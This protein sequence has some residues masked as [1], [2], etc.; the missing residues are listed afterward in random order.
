MARL[1]GCDRVN[2]EN[3]NLGCHVISPDLPETEL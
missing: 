1:V 3:C 2:A